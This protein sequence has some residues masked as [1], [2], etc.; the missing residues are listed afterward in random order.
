M[1]HGAIAQIDAVVIEEAMLAG[2]LQMICRCQGDDPN[3][4]FSIAPFPS[5]L[6]WSVG[7]DCRS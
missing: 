1:S 4:K 5:E 3:D 2:D 6:K 7:G